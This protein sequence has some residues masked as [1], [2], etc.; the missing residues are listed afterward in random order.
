[1]FVFEE[2]AAQLQGLEDCHLVLPDS[3]QTALQLIILSGE[4]DSMTHDAV[5]QN[6]PP[7][8]GR[9]AKPCCFFDRYRNLEGL[10]L[11]STIKLS[12]TI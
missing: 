11:T 5:I 1:M 3:S 12:T 6:S 7:R 9:G 10:D 4:I 2:F 8:T